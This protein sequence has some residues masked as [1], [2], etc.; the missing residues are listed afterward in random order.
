MSIKKDQAIK[1][2]TRGEYV[3]VAYSAATRLPYVTCDP[4]TFNDQAWFF[5]SEAGVKEFGKKCA[6]NKTLLMGMRFDRKNYN[7]LYGS[8][9]AIGV[10]SIVW[11]DVGGK[12]E[13]DISA[14]A[15]QQDY[16]KLEE[17][18]RPLLNPTLQL[19]AIYFLQEARRPVAS[20]EEH[21]DLKSLEEEFIVNLLKSEFLIAMTVDPADPKKMSV[22]FL[23]GKD[24]KALQPFYSDIIEFQKFSKGKKE[25]RA[26]KVPFSKLKDIMVKD[27]EGMVLDPMSLNLP[28]DR[29]QLEVILDSRG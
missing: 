26:A 18:K 22:P 29:K 27:V 21:G 14:I 9:Y 16:S 7:I 5:S 25:I 17:N 6:E 13:V 11:N 8:L 12:C 10:N 3:F 28:L 20:M 15:K 24:G 23:K 19:S 1:A 2:M 4:E